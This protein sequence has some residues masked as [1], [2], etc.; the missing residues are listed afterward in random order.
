MSAAPSKNADPA[1]AI[2]FQGMLGANS[3]MACKQV[4]PAMVPLPCKTFDDAFAAVT[5]GRAVL[6]M[7]PIENSIAGRVADIHHLLPD[8]G[9][10]II[11]EHFLRIRYTLMAPKGA[12][13]EGLKRVYSHVQSLAQCRKFI[14]GLGLDAIVTADNAGAAAEVAQRNNLEEAA[15]AP[16]LAAELY[17]LAPLRSDVE[18]MSTNTTRF[19]IMSRERRD[20][21]PST[22]DCLTSFIFQVRS[23]P[24]ALYKSLGG[25][26]TNGVNVV[27]LES[28]MVDS[29]F[30]VAQFYAE[31]DGHP[32]DA[33]V[34]RAFDELKYFSTKFEIL[35][36]YPASKFRHEA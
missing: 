14:R 5:E 27:K 34:M 6:G 20:A 23:I 18:D 13:V 16:P 36:A 21:D 7:I 8:S 26:A 4:Y 15:I 24:A 35:G 30:T 28:Y 12:T 25:F 3:H 32:A 19:V 9:L 31:I 29:S 2:A 10:Y 17:G 33:A 22:S 11:G 1:N